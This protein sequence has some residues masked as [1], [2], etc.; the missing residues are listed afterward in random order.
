MATR[1]VDEKLVRRASALAARTVPFKV[2]FF[3]HQMF[4][5]ISTS[6]FT[7]LRNEFLFGTTIT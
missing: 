1:E 4:H 3:A 7:M 5:N 6:A 2:R